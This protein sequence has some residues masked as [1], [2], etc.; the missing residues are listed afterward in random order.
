MEDWCNDI[1]SFHD[2][3]QIVTLLSICCVL[4]TSH[5]FSMFNLSAVPE[6][7][8]GDK[9]IVVLMIRIKNDMRY[10]YAQTIL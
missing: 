4:Q 5:L 6:I 9:F 7:G 3:L 1:F 2:S 10:L 8:L